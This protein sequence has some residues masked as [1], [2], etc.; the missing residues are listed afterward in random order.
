M[1]TN[2]RLVLFTD[3]KKCSFKYHGVKV[4]N[5]KWIKGSEEHKAPQVHTTITINMYA[6]LSLY[7][8]NL[9]HEVADTKGLTT[10]FNNRMGQAARNITCDVDGMVMQE[11]L[12]PGGRSFSAKEGGLHL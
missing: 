3:Q 1:K 12:L 7:G 4:G 10:P 11:S 2:W 6:G 8:M 5:G 9:A